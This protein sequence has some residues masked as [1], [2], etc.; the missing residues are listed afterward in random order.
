MLKEIG[1]SAYLQFLYNVFCFLRRF[2][3]GIS[4]FVKMELTEFQDEPRFQQIK[5]MVDAYGLT[6]MDTVVW[7][8]KGRH[9][10]MG[11]Q[12]WTRL[13]QSRYKRGHGCIK[14]GF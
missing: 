13:Y 10:C 1:T 9:G 11:E 2:I 3:Y 8:N 14:V 6:R 5:I 4:Y 7:V 12:G